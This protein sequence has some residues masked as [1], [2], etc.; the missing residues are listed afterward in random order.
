MCSSR[1]RN[2]TKLK[3]AYLKEQKFL[4]WELKDYW[5]AAKSIYNLILAEGGATGTLQGAQSSPGGFFFSVFH[6]YL[7]NLKFKIRDLFKMCGF[8]KW[9]RVEQVDLSTCCYNLAQDNLFLFDKI[10]VF[11]HY[12]CFK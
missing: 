4:K 12:P 2:L 3:D 10:N 11:V 7:F 8:K 6:F 1:L 5:L 9:S